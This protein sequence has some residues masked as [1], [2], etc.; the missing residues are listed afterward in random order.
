MTEAVEGAVI[1]YKGK[2]YVA[3]PEVTGSCDE[4]AAQGTFCDKVIRC[5]DLE[6]RFV[7]LITPVMNFEVV[8]WVGGEY[9]MTEVKRV[10]VHTDDVYK[11]ENYIHEHY[12]VYSI[13]RLYS[14]QDS[15]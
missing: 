1:H 11:A 6:T 7:E 14:K 5:S 2:D 13:T 12:N 9:M 3:V 10:H 15:K 8:V 4:C